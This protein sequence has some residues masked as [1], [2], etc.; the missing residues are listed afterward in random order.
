MSTLTA[1]IRARLPQSDVTLADWSAH[2]RTAG[3]LLRAALDRLSEHETASGTMEFVRRRHGRRLALLA[4][5]EMLLAAAEAAGERADKLVTAD[6]AALVPASTAAREL[7]AA[8]LDGYRAVYD[9]DAQIPL[10]ADGRLVRLAAAISRHAAVS[11]RGEL[12]NRSMPPAAAVRVALTGLA[13]SERLSPSQVRSRV[14]ARFPSWTEFR[15]GRI[16]TP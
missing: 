13:Q 14:T 5:D 1:E 2:D 10:P 4:E 9:T 7:R 11:G 15:C 8:F 6:V 3:G 16:W 12:H